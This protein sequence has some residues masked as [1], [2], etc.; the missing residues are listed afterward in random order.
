MIRI[1]PSLAAA[2]H[3]NRA[4]QPKPKHTKITIHG[5]LS[6][7]EK[8]HQRER[9]KWK[10]IV[11]SALANMNNEVL[12]DRFP[13][14][15]RETLQKFQLENWIGI[16]PKMGK[17]VHSRKR[18]LTTHG[19]IACVGLEVLKQLPNA[20]SAERALAQLFEAIDCTVKVAEKRFCHEIER[21]GSRRFF[22]TDPISPDGTAMKPYREKIYSAMQTSH[23]VFVARNGAIQV[24]RL[25]TPKEFI[26]I[27]RADKKAQT[28]ILSQ[29]P[30]N[31]DNGRMD[32][33]EKEISKIYFGSIFELYDFLNELESGL[34]QERT[35]HSGASDVHRI[36]F[37]IPFDY[38]RHI[39]NGLLKV[40]VDKPGVDGA[41]ACSFI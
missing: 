15:Y 28:A 40:L 22:D 19:L 33:T 27:V 18:P 21:P 36:M 2:I 37:R 35:T 41:R 3:A 30:L 34:H 29:Q 16:P 4:N 7:D 14:F 12:Q 32:H 31:K 9:L 39:D 11:E 5:G 23:I 8:L 13:P 17:R 26:E 25:P 20:N 24:L 6:I 10:P 1:N 38:K